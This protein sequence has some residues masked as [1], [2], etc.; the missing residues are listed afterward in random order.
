V[1]LRLD[2]VG[3]VDFGADQRSAIDAFT[4]HF[5]APDAGPK[6]EERSCGAR[7]VRIVRWGRFA[8]R[9]TEVGPASLFT[10]WSYGRVPDERTG[11]PGP[12]PGAPVLALRGDIAV[13]ASPVPSDALADD[14]RDAFPA[15]N[16]D[17]QPIEAGVSE[18]VWILQHDEN[19]LDVYL[20]AAPDGIVIEQLHGYWV[21]SDLVC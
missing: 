19:K 7:T 15:A 6:L 11:E 12:D 10:S 9:F 2:G 8:A 17:A 18:A 1:E 20:R 16:L 13:L 5:G 14:L 21:R 3:D 4:G